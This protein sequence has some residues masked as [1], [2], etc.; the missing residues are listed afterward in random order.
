MLK[1][2][3]KVKQNQLIHKRQNNSAVVI[4]KIDEKQENMKKSENEIIVGKL[5]PV[6][7]E[8]RI[9]WF[10]STKTL[11]TM[12][13]SVITYEL[14]LTQP[15]SES[16]NGLPNMT[17]LICRSCVGVAKR[18][19]VPRLSICNGFRFPRIPEE[20]QQLTPLEE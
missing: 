14:Q 4:P 2:L 20:I 19:T 13:K 5:H 1:R 18:G 7:I 10:K 9:L 6:Q 12:I 3:S 11:L 8:D 15:F 17:K 16:I